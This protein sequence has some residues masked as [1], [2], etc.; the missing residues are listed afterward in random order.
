MRAL[1]LLATLFPTAATAFQPI[2]DR[3]MFLA[4]VEAK[5][6]TAPGIGLIVS[7]GGAITGRTF[8]VD[9]TGDWAWRGPYFC[10]TLS[11]GEEMLPLD[12]QTVA[13]QGDVVRFRANEGMG[14]ATDLRLR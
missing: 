9:V 1:L 13:V 5:R 3:E 2:T 6:L 4:I 12:C 7:D 11:S 10:R 14:E 8:G